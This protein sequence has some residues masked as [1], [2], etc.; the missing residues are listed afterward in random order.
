MLLH[1]QYRMCNNNNNEFGFENINK[2]E[3][4]ENYCQNI[5]QAD[6]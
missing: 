2:N 5:N 1:H 4:K 3:F 6:F